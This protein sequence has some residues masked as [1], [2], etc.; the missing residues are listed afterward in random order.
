MNNNRTITGIRA[1]LSTA[2]A[3]RDEYT[4]L[5]KTAYI[6]DVEFLLHELEL[7]YLHTTRYNSQ[8]DPEDFTTVINLDLPNSLEDP[9]NPWRP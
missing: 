9:K 6:E 7:A 2:K 8:A 4:S 5:W 3:T 1:T